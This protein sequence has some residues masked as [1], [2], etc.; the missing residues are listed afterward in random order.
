MN[1]NYYIL[2][3]VLVLGLLLAACNSDTSNPV[4]TATTGSLYVAS[5]PTGAQ[6]WVD[7]VNTSKVTPDSVTGVS[8]GSHSLTLKLNAYFDTTSS[9]TVV[10]GLPTPIAIQL[11]GWT[12]GNRVYYDTLRV[13]ESGGTGANQPSGIILSSGLA[14]SVVSG[15]HNLVDIY[16]STN[17]GLV[18]ATAFSNVNTRSTSFNVPAGTSSTNLFDRAASPAYVAGPNWLTQISDQTTNYFYLYDNDGHYSKMIITDRSA[19]GVSPKW[20]KVKWFYSSVA[21]NGNF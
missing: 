13:W 12:G 6:I 10:A 16:Y 4:T 11:T 17:G 9:Q 20:L 1:K 8:A 15:N 19:T 7:G 5:V 18:L 21:G 2:P 3:L 14:S